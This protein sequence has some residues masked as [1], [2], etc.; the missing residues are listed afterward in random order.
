[1]QSSTRRSIAY[2]DLTRDDAPDIPAHIYDMIQ[3]LD[4]DTPFYTGTYAAIPA[5]TSKVKGSWYWASDQSLLYFNNGASWTQLM[6]GSNATVAGDITARSGLSTQTA[7][8]QVGPSSQSGITFQSNET[9]LYRDSASSLTLQGA[10]SATL[11]IGTSSQPGALYLYDTTTTA[12]KLQFFYSTDA[13]PRYAVQTDGTTKWG[14]GGASALDTVLYR[15]AAGRLDLQSG[16]GT[17]DGIL[18]AG[19]FLSF[20]AAGS[21]AFTNYL[22]STDANP[23]YAIYGNGQ[24]SW[25]VGGATAL[26]TSLSRVAAGQLKVQGIG[27]GQAILSVDPSG[28]TYGSQLSL[29]SR[30]SG[31]S[32][33]NYI[34]ADPTSAYLE[35]VILGSSTSYYRFFTGPTATEFARIQPDQGLT[36]AP[37]SFGLRIMLGLSDAYAT[38]RVDKNGLTQWGPGGSTAPD[39]TLQRISAGV[40]QL[41]GTLNSTAGYQVNGTAQPKI[42]SGA[43]SSGPPG[44]PNDGDIWMATNVDGNGAMWMFRYNAGSASTYKWEFAGGSPV[45]VLANL[46]VWTTGSAWTNFNTSNASWTAA[47]AGEY[48]AWGGYGLLSAPSGTS[49]TT[50]ASA[51]ISINGAAPAYSQT[52]FMGTAN[53]PFEV[54][55]PAEIYTVAATNT[56]ALQYA[57]DYAPN[58]FRPGSITIVPRRIS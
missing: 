56:I 28:G 17:L 26:D 34:Y 40:L 53:E 12:Y 9:Y 52:V 55:V 54:V 42:T 38:Y 4:L 31:S 58:G 20:Q 49:A 13:N 2:P 14:P 41:T 36:I 46:N 22:V 16:S 5:A 39:I 35:F 21:Q 24:L 10:S 6:S 37:S 15:S 47:R 18:R 44:S 33:A 8:G 11:K 32:T 43:F 1:M 51:G 19:K 25:G 50:T 3:A 57:V 7:I 27:T 48:S 30:N 29:V 23:A 45:V